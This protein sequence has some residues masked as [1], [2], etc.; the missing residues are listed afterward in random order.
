MLNSVVYNSNRKDKGVN[1]SK[2]MLRKNKIII[3]TTII[4][5]LVISAVLIVVSLDRLDFENY[6]LNYNLI[7]ANFSD[8]YIYGSGLHLIG[9]SNG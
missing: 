7:T 9:F 6:G 2:I 8:D 3:V 1:Y 4:S 5:I